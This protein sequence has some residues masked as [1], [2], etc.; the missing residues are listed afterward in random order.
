MF[1][2]GDKVRLVRNYPDDN[3]NLFAGDE[4]IVV[5]VCMPSRPGVDWGKQCGHNCNG[6]A[7]AGQ[8]WYVFS[9]D[10][11]LVGPADDDYNISADKLI[12]FLVTQGEEG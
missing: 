10:I 1:N 3:H 9:G 12:D 2:I 8:G 5:D 6:D 7:K 4:G 11:E